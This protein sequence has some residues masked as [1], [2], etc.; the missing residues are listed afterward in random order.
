MAGP[1]QDCYQPG[2]HRADFAGCGAAI[3]IHQ[4]AISKKEDRETISFAVTIVGAGVG[5]YGLMKAAENI[6][7]A[8]AE[9]FRA[10]SLS[11]VERWNAPGYWQVKAEWRKLNDELD[12][13]TPEKRDAALDEDVSRRNVAVEIL[14][15]YEEMATGINNGS[16]DG[17]LLRGYWEPVIIN[18]FDRYEYWIRQHRIRKR[19]PGYFEE[20]EKLVSKWKTP[21]P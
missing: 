3:V 7:Q 4:Y 8:N 12:L 14:N 18:S 20:L 11:F 9:R 2:D 1:A 16:L 19:A 6:R 13:L 15:F 17:E 5:I 21:R 10:A